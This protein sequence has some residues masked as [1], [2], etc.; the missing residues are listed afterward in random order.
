MNHTPGPWFSV[1][2]W[3]EHEDDEVPDICTCN[4]EDLGQG[5]LKRSYEEMCANAKLI[6]AAPEMLDALVAIGLIASTSLLVL[7]K[8]KDPSVKASLKSIQDIVQEIIVS[9]EEL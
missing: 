4:P 6:A 2:A 8:I 1:G 5:H 9:E 7:D 3:V